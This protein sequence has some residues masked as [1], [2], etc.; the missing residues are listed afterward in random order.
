LRIR[1]QAGRTAGTRLSL[2]FEARFTAQFLRATKKRD[3]QA[4]RGA[5][6][7]IVSAPYAARRSETLSY[8]W[9]GFRSAVYVGGK[10]IIFRVCEECVRK[11]QEALAPFRTH[12]PAPPAHALARS[13]RAT[14]RNRVGTPRHPSDTW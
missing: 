3:L 9:A 10:R 12:T 5:C 4:L 7:E 14:G 11:H 2:P 8:E 13:A 6:E 1:T